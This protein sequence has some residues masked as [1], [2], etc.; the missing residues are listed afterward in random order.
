MFDHDGS[1]VPTRVD[2]RNYEFW[3]VLLSRAQEEGER[4]ALEQAHAEAQA[5][6]IPAASKVSVRN[7]HG[8][9]LSLGATLTELREQE[10]FRS[11]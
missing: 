2:A 3:N 5:T 4:V 1:R 9:E 11:I 6:S 8:S 10:P 7:D